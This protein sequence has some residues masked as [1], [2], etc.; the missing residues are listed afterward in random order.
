M[1]PELLAV[2]LFYTHL[3]IIIHIRFRSFRDSFPSCRLNAALPLTPF[4]NSPRT[5]KAPPQNLCRTI[6]LALSGKPPGNPTFT[7]HRVQLEARREK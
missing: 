1:D 6:I 4:I 3:G 5:R 7:S 2:K